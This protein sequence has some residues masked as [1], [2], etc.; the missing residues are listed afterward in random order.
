MHKLTL[1]KISILKENCPNALTMIVLNSI[2][3]KLENNQ[4]L[5][6]KDL[7]FIEDYWNLVSINYS[8]R[9]AFANRRRNLQK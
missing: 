1:E 4:N 2:S 5:L 6:S 9:P 3:E 8:T 7:K